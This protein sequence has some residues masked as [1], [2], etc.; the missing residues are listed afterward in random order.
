MSRNQYFT[1]REGCRIAYRIDGPA[2]AVR[3]HFEEE[4]LKYCA[5]E[6]VPLDF[7]STKAVSSKK[8]ARGA[9]AGGDSAT[10]RSR[11]IHSR[12]VIRNLQLPGLELHFTEWRSAYT[13]TDYIYDQYHRAAFILD[14]IK[15]PRSL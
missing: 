10:V 6:P 7:I 9:V 2:S 15:A 13:L 11:L 4:L 12:E 3:H 5:R 1:T 14:K 8:A